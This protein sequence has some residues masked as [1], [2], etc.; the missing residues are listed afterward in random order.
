V[1][2]IVAVAL[3]PVF[4]AL[5]LSHGYDE[6]RLSRRHGRP[7]ERAAEKAAPAGTQAP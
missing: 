6:T 1:N 5:K 2:L 7:R 4:R 3:T